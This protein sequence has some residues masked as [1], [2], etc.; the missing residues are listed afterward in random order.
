IYEKASEVGGTWRD[1]T[2]PGCSSGVAIHFYSLSTD[3]NPDFDRTHG[4]QR[5]LLAYLRGL[6][7]K[8]NLRQHIVFNTQVVSAREWIYEQ[9]EKEYEAIYEAE[10]LISALGILE[11]TRYPDILGLN[12]FG[13]ELFHSGAWNHEVVLKG[14]T[15]AVIGNGTSGALL[16]PAISQDPSVNVVNI[17]RTPVWY[18]PLSDHSYGAISKWMF[19]NIPLCFRLSR[20]GF[21]T[22]YAPSLHRPNVD[23][24]WDGIERITKDGILTKKGENLPFH[25]IIFATGYIGVSSYPALA[26]FAPSHYHVKMS[27]PVLR[28]TEERRDGNQTWELE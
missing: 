14:K 23:M 5:E 21:S 26:R 10:V 1:N 27:R 3:L 19:R 11:V 24:N 4:S 28:G 7:D 8:Y 13:G 20:R 6:V 16:V 18:F 22:G 9:L 2:Y 17:C 12:E 25:V 15:V